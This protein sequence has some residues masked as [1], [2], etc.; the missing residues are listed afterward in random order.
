[1]SNCWVLT[2]GKIGMLNQALAVAE[3]LELDI[4]IKQIKLKPL[5]EWF[6]PKFRWF[7]ACAFAEGSDSLEG[8][9]PS[10]VVA[11]GRRSIIAAL[12][13][14]ECSPSTKLIYVQ[15]PKISPK[16]FD[17]VICPKH[18]Q[19]QGDNVISIVGTVNRLKSDLLL[20]EALRFGDHFAHLPRPLVGVL[21]GGP[22]RKIPFTIKHLR[23]FIKTLMFLN[24]KYKAGFIITC[25][26]RSPPEFIKELHA[27][28]GAN[29][30]FYIYDNNGDNPYYAM[31]SICKVLIVSADSVNMISEAAS[32]DKPL[33][34]LKLP[35]K[36]R[37]FERF[38]Q[39][40]ISLGRAKWLDKDLTFDK[41][42]PLNPMAELL[43]RLRALLGIAKGN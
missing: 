41:V 30:N 19:L 32:T 5:W 21:I 4:E 7:K 18:D 34:L 38:H 43:Q 39:Q 14:K 36:S 15:D 13:I 31:L 28:L 9:Y 20:R 35:C 1:M 26:R 11:C 6:S 24:D 3:G 40:V 33:Y 17:A 12:Y 2:E 42:V 37:K 16:L 8:P 29:P 27:V 10:F 23:S 22:T 25:S